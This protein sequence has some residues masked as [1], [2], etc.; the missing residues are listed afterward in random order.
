MKTVVIRGQQKW[1]HFLIQ[2]KAEATLLEALNDAGQAGWEMVAIHYYKDPKG[3]MTWIAFLKRPFTGQTPQA[4]AAST[5]AQ[6][7]APAETDA[8]PE[9]SKAGFN[10]EGEVFEVTPLPH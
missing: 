7:A 1:E 4:P 5:A 8:N 3:T 10:L 6:A 2:R 9:A